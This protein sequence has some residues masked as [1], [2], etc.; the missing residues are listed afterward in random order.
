MKIFVGD[1]LKSEAHTLV[2]TVNCEGVMGKGIALEF[3][4]KFPDMFKDYAARCSRGEVRLGEPYIYK[5]LTGPNVINFPTKDHW[6]S[7]SRWNLRRDW[8]GGGG[9]GGVGM[10][11]LGW[12]N[13][14]GAMGRYL[15][16]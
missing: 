15:Q 5:Q 7:L 6:R 3:K 2:N 12:A 10:A 4:K 11:V 1:I 9:G 13:W 14:N 8:F 16:K